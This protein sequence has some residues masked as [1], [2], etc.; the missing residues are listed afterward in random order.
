MKILVTG[1]RRYKNK[2]R[3]WAVMDRWL[4]ADQYQGFTLISGGAAGVDAL[5]AEWAHERHLPV[6]YYHAQWKRPDG[7][8]D[9]SAGPRRNQQMLDQGQPW[10]VIAFPGG[11]GTA[12][13]VKIAKRA[14]IKVF[15]IPW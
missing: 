9:R 5:A 10:R 1:G 8:T 11:P 7:S 2:E 14:R 12:H 4:Q 15:S 13:M 3:V 6:E